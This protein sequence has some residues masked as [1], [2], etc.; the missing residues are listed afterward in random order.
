MPMLRSKELLALDEVTEACQ[1]AA[2][3]FGKF[4]ESLQDPELARV[5]SAA[6]KRHRT[7]VMR[8]D[9]QVQRLGALP[10][11]PDPDREALEWLA[12]WLH[13]LVAESK[14]ST[15]LEKALEIERSVQQAIAKELGVEL[16]PPIQSLLSEL[17]LEVD[18]SLERLAALA[19]TASAPS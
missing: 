10:S 16:S 3:H 8:L 5:L 12:T 19:D 18:S 7:Q 6:A 4:S 13:S 2:D 1:L 14:R 9:Q 15:L 11:R 17:Q